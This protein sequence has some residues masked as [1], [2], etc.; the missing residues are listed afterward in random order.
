M[1]LAMRSL[2]Q[3]RSIVAA[4]S[5]PIHTMNSG[6]GERIGFESFVRPPGGD[7][8]ETVYRRLKPPAKFVRP[9]G[10]NATFETHRIVSI[11]AEGIS[12]EGSRYS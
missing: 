1:R 8:I 2:Y 7:G 9:T 10:G 6:P 12:R 11:G 4:E 3:R 5:K